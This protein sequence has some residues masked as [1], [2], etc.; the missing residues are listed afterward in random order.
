ME[1]SV[2]RQFVFNG[3]KKTKLKK[4]VAVSISTKVVQ[5]FSNSNRTFIERQNERS[6]RN[7]N[8]QKR[9]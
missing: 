1:R 3:L 8:A 2:H 5:L 4:K 9:C 7:D 6:I